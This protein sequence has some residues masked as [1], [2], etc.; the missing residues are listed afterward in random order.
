VFITSKDKVSYTFD[1]EMSGMRLHGSLQG[2]ET[3]RTGLRSC[4]NVK[5]GRTGARIAPSKRFI[6]G[7]RVG[8]SQASLAPKVQSLVAATAAPTAPGPSVSSQIDDGAILD[9]VIVGAGISGLTTALVSADVGEAPREHLNPNTS[10]LA[11]SKT[12]ATGFP[13]HFYRRFR[14]STLAK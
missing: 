4:A 14:R 3:Q 8:A 11:L 5:L 2:A 10:R 1:S 6:S 9:T 7:R 13:L 12:N